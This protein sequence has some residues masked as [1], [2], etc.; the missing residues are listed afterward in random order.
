MQMQADFKPGYL[1]C[2][3]AQAHISCAPSL[4]LT[5]T[6][7]LLNHQ[8]CWPS[9][10]DNSHRKRAQSESY[11]CESCMSLSHSLL[12]LSVSFSWSAWIVALLVWASAKSLQFPCCL[13]CH[14]IWLQ[15]REIRVVS[16]S[17][18]CCS[19]NCL[20]AW[21]IIWRCCLTRQTARMLDFKPPA[22]AAAAAAV[23]THCN[24]SQFVCCSYQLAPTAPSYTLFKCSTVARLISAA[25]LTEIVT[26]RS[27]VTAR[28]QGSSPRP[29]AAPLA[30]LAQAPFNTFHN[31][32]HLLCVCKSCIKSFPARVLPARLLLCICCIFQ[33]DFVQFK[34][35][36]GGGRETESELPS[37]QL[38][39]WS[40]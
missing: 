31:L 12:I 25:E 18:C 23:T 33:L 2:T 3:H 22:A 30:P 40:I 1:C 11:S 37:R 5:P 27:R 6:S 14:L 10:C 35:Q 36:G 15:L 29:L 26:S 38:L 16:S 20:L 32:R 17:C 39:N 8:K 13:R 28:P 7:P 24:R 21:W 19:C 34:R 4:A 9:N